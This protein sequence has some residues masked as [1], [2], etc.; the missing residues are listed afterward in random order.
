[1]RSIPRLLW[2]AAALAPLTLVSCGGRH[3]EPVTIVFSCLNDWQRP[4]RLGPDLI[5]EFTRKTGIIVKTLPY[6]EELAERRAQH[7]TWLRQH[8]ATPDVYESDIVD[9]PGLADQMIDLAPFVG[10]DAKNYMP[11]VLDNLTFD[12]KL[13]AIPIN[14]DVGLLFYRTD[15]LRKYEYASP[16]RTWQELEQMAVAIQKGERAGGNPGFWGFIWEGADWEGL[17]YTALEWQSSW[18]G[19]HII[20]PDGTISV[21]NPWTI[22]ALQRAKGWVNFISPPG[23]VAYRMVDVMNMW[24]SGRAAFMRNWPFMFFASNAPES[25]VGGKIDATYL[26]SGGAGHS[27]TLGGW[28]LSVSRYSAHPT[29]AAQFAMYLTSRDAQTRCARELHWMSARQDVYLDPDVQR[30]NPHY[31]RLI[32]DFSRIAVA[33]PSAVTKVAYT[34]ASEAYAHAVHAVLTGEKQAPDAMAELEKTLTQSTG[35]KTSSA[36]P[37]HPIPIEATLR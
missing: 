10:T 31:R 24:Q 17:T 30:A 29:E 37:E 36:R 25:Q 13:I 4:S 20:E 21:N 2:A 33:R 23:V 7:L 14:T 5:D 28:Q 15:L 1:M 22:A 32:D 26:P 8:S 35:C 12:G 11:S 27:G 9:L 16:P 6:S 34:A 19:G 3:S 18:G